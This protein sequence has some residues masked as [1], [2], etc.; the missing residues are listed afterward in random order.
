MA[1]VYYREVNCPLVGGSIIGGSIVS[2]WFLFHCLF[3]NKAYGILDF[4]ADLFD[5]DLFSSSSKPSSAAKKKTTGAS[6]EDDLFAAKPS[7]PTKT[8]DSLFDKPPE[9]IFSSGSSKAKNATDDDIFA[10]SKRGDDVKK[11]DNI[12]ADAPSKKRPSQKTKKGT[13]AV[14]RSFNKSLG[15]RFGGWGGCTVCT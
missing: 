14:S 8:E 7:K 13:D 11:L 6:L 10:P 4:H 2:H 9:D 1:S 5:D 12:F 15:N 3:T